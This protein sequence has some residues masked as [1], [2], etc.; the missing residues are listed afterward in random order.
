[1]GFYGLDFYNLYGS[2]EA[3]L[4]YL[5]A[6]D[7]AMAA[8][9]RQRYNC[10]LPWRK[11]PALYSDFMESGKYRG[12]GYETNAVLADI[13]R[14]QSWY[15]QSG[16]E[17]YFHARQNAWLARNAELYYRTKHQGIVNSWN[18]RDDNLFDSLL[19]ILRHRGP[20]SKAV[21]WAHNTHIGDARATDMNAAGEINLGQRV[22]QVF[23]NNTYLIGFGT[24]HGTVTAASRWGGPPETMPIP[25][26][27]QDSY[28]HLFHQVEAKNF[29]LPLRYP[30]HKGI[31]E[32]LLTPRLQRGIGSTYSPDPEKEMKYHYSHAS[33]P[34]QFDEYIWI[35]ETHAV[36]P[37]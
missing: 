35:D 17:G 7:P 34:N 4:G 6:V 33:L 27:H 36:K 23:G 5:Q 1:V 31:R 9:A 26:S 18:L 32:Q 12:C 37:Q 14:R 19:T 28:G 21:V 2:I 16:S 10:L 20:A 3:V 8:V 15:E 24:D 25:T 29:L 22:R 30:L 13:Q 11:D